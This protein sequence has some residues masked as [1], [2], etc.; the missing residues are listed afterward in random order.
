M[1]FWSSGCWGNR[2]SWLC[3]TKR[4]RKRA[5]NTIN[6]HSNV[7]GVWANFRRNVF[8]Q[9]PIRNKNLSPIMQKAV[10]SHKCTGNGSGYNEP[11]WFNMKK[12]WGHLGTAVWSNPNSQGFLSGIR[13]KRGYHLHDT[14]MGTRVSLRVC[15]EPYITMGSHEYPFAIPFQ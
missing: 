7:A 3:W 15:R 2:L 11:C 4:C 5:V 10:Q 8:Y 14:V 13:V 9:D 6:L 12:G 1:T